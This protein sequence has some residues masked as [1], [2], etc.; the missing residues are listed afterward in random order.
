MLLQSIY[1]N[2]D[3]ILEQ[4]RDYTGVVPYGYSFC[5]YD[6]KISLF[7]NDESRYVFLPLIDAKG[8]STANLIMPDISRS[9]TTPKPNY[10]SDQATYV[11]K[12]EDPKKDAN[13]IEKHL[14]FVQHLQDLYDKTN[15]PEI[16]VILNFLHNFDYSKTPPEILCNHRIVFEVD[17][18][19]D[20]F[21]NPLVANVIESELQN[22][23]L[24]KN[25][26]LDD[27]VCLVSGIK[28]NSIRLYNQKIKNLP[29]TQTT[30]YSLLSNNNE[31]YLAAWPNMC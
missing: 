30:G 4:T 28:C 8:R 9:G 5:D 1:K 24:D 2:Y 26:N 18:S 6:W 13:V 23:T 10:L 7:T 21:L 31:I 11:F 16:N 20:Y 27:D 12:V 17:N 14:F 15:L 3:S 29:G 25:K 19:T 22:E